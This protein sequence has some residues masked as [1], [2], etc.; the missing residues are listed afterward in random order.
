MTAG[1]FQPGCQLTADG[2]YAAPVLTPCST[3][4]PMPPSAS[5]SQ[6]VR[7]THGGRRSR[8][9]CSG[10]GRSTSFPTEGA[11][12]RLTSWRRPS[13]PTPWPACWLSGTTALTAWAVWERLEALHGHELAR[14]SVAISFAVM[15]LLWSNQE[16]QYR[17]AGLLYA[18]AVIYTVDQA[19]LEQIGPLQPVSLV[20]DGGGSWYWP[21]VRC[22]DT[23]ATDSTR[24]PESL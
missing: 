4:R 8:H 2:R 5:T 1:S 7:R 18:L 12:G 14:L 23:R 3:A 22:C 6:S 24:G 21:P 15:A 10:I 20:V 17:N 19:G 16:G 13:S 11:G 9:I